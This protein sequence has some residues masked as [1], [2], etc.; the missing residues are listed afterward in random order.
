M[1]DG[2]CVRIPLEVMDFLRAPGGHSLI[3]KG[4][5]GSGKTTFALQLIEE[6]EEEQP[7]YFLSSRVSDEALFKQF[8]W[9]REKVRRQEVLK[10]GKAFLR[11]KQCDPS[12]SDIE[13]QGRVFTAKRFLKTISTS[14]QEPM[15]VRSELKRLEG[16]IESGGLD[17]D[18]E[19]DIDD[20]GLTINLGMILPELEIA[21]DIAEMNLP[22]KT[23][24]ILDSIEGLSERYGISSKRILNVLQKDLVENSGT[25]VIYILET[26]EKTELDYLGDGVIVLENIE[27]K[28]RKLRHM[29][30][31]KLRGA[32]IDRCT[33]SPSMTAGSRR[34][35]QSRIRAWPPW[36]CPP[37]RPIPTMNMS[38]GAPANPILSLAVCQRG[39]Y[40]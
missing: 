33:I 22:Q 27:V 24:V 7:E 29:R 31:D 3:I 19:V 40:L 34:S 16:L 37:R 35:I 38:L 10:A 9:L 14:S 36:Y 32:R 23:L 13:H 18:D 26:S 28:G 2:R 11:A 21:Y 20:D 25:N 17:F 12:E 4:D 1:D 15:V 30:I 39:R 5:A 8:P 6:L